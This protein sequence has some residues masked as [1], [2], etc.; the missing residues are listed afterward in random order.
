M[1]EITSGPEEGAVDDSVPKVGDKDDSGT[2]LESVDDTDP[3]L[4]GGDDI[5]EVVE[6]GWSLECPGSSL[7][8]CVEVCPGSTARVYGVC[9]R[10]C[11]TRCPE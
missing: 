6:A 7:E 8:A 5:T 11:A 4:E 2:T 1:A 10:G 9:V 3:K